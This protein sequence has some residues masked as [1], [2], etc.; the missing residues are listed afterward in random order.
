[1][2]LRRIFVCG[3][4]GI[5]LAGAR[6]FAADSNPTNVV[7]A[8]AAVYVPDTSHQNDPLPDG[9]LAWNS[10]EQGTT[11][12]A[13]VTNALFT[14]S[15]TNVSPG[16]VAILEV[17]SSCGCTTAQLP[18][19]PWIIP[20]GTNGQLGLTVNLAGRTG[21]QVKTVDV[22]TDR[23]S[24][25]LILKINILPPV[26]PSQSE[27]NRARALEMAKA[28]RQAVFHGDCAACHVKLGEGKYGKPLYFAVCANCHESKT[29]ASMVP[30][31]HNIKTPTSVD[32]WQ[33]WIAHGKAGS[34]M[35][36]FSTADGGPLSEMQITSLAGYLN[37]TIPSQPAPPP[38][39][40]PDGI[41]AWN[42]LTQETT[43]A[44]DAGNAIFTFSFTNVSPGNVT[45]L[46]VHS[47][48]GCTTAQ[49]PPLPW[50]IP[51]GTN[52]QFGLTVNVAGQGGMQVKTVNVKTDKG[53]AQLI[54]KINIL[55]SVSPSRSGANRARFDD[56]LDRPAGRHSR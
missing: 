27:A 16:N 48:C 7:A 53:F 35:P 2:K 18:P 47:S 41:L 54:L 17:H 50:I 44:A 15:F 29:R 3:I 36:A 14:F 13:D 51:A 43:V 56:G 1:M 4:T 10:L 9:V 55:P 6:L 38:D 25:Q 42:S 8:T 5:V 46:E 21:M 40:L 32:F 33:T 22:K 12:A 30:D 26:A 49:L 45:I 34:L 37:A 19:L 20:P 28:D 39:P 31:L 24:A 52:G 23:G 11:V